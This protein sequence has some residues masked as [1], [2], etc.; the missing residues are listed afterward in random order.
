MYDEAN[1]IKEYDT[2]FEQPFFPSYSILYGWFKGEMMY[3]NAIERKKN[4]EPKCAH[5]ITTF[6][7]IIQLQLV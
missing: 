1:I 3:F 4:D 6:I 2:L 5:S 7:H